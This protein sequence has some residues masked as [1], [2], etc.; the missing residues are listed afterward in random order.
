ME[1]KKRDRI[2]WISAIVLTPIL[3]VLLATNVF[4]AGKRTAPSRAAGAAGAAA[5][6]AAQPMPLPPQP[7][8]ASLAPL[9]PRRAEAQRKMA[10]QLPAR[11][12]FSAAPRAAPPAAPSADAPSAYAPPAEAPARPADPALKISAI[13]LRPDG[14]RVAMINGRMLGEGDRTGEWTITKV[15]PLNVTLD[16]GMRQIVAGPR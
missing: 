14:K 8:A 4:K 13:I 3:I 6:A 12:P 16:N 7:P 10:E 9:D 5:A 15:N 11:N 1:Q 2:A